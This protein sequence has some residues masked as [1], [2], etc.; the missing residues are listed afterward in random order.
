MN[1]PV[2]RS[3]A[4]HHHSHATADRA[5]IGNPLVPQLNRLEGGV[6]SSKI[7]AFP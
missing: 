4:R 7:S 1:L 3:P 6:R 5:P 2:A